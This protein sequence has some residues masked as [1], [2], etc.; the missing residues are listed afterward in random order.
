MESDF[1]NDSSCILNISNCLSNS[2][3]DH[4][5]IIYS[6]LKWYCIFNTNSSIRTIN[7]NEANYKI[8]FTVIIVILVL[9]GVQNCII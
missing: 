6:R 7:Y 5:K 8:I 2:F 1:Q 9:Y 4:E 3:E